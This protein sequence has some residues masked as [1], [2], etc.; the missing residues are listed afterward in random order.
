MEARKASDFRHIDWF[1][2]EGPGKSYRG[3]GF[4]VY[5]GQ[6]LLTFGPGRIALPASMLWSFPG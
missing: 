5:L 3:A 4:V 6:H 2:K 1:L